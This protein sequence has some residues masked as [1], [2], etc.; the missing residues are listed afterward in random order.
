MDWGNLPN[1]AKLLYIAE[2]PEDK[3][4]VRQKFERAGLNINYVDGS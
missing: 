1:P 2:K 3:E 4:T